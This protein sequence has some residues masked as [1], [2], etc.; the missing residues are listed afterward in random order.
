MRSS[1][2]THAVERDGSRFRDRE[3]ALPALSEDG[4]LRW[5][6]RVRSARALHFRPQR[7]TLH[8]MVRA[9]GRQVRAFPGLL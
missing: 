3:S 6:N 5:I 9:A 2:I 1:R 7:R 4:T 8:G